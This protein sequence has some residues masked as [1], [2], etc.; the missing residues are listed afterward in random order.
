MKDYN[1]MALTSFNKLKEEIKGTKSSLEELCKKYNGWHLDDTGK[2]FDLNYEC[3][4][5]TIRPDENGI[6]IVSPFGIQVFDD[7][8]EEPVK[9]YDNI[10]E[11]LKTASN[12][13]SNQF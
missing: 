11:E 9:W 2:Y 12:L 6:I 1:K 13:L 7:E 4:T 5:L 10:E 8:T 3:L